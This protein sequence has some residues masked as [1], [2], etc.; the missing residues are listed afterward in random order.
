MLAIEF[1]QAIQLAV[2]SDI[3]FNSFTQHVFVFLR[4]YI[5]STPIQVF[6]LARYSLP[7]VQRR[8]LH[9]FRYFVD[10]FRRRLGNR[11]SCLA[12]RFISL[13]RHGVSW[14]RLMLVPLR[15]DAR[16]VRAGC[17]RSQDENQWRHG[18]NYVEAGRPQGTSLQS[19]FWIGMGKCYR[20]KRTNFLCLSHPHKYTPVFAEKRPAN[21][22]AIGIIRKEKGPGDNIYIL[23]DRKTPIE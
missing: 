8:T 7:S 12:L 20:G 1:L 2:G 18:A 13:C 23:Q 11:A 22:P 19:R 14:L 21:L 15:S 6:P 16:P 9:V 5:S 3:L 4:K 10:S 17:P